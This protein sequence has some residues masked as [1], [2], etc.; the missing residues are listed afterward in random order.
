MKMEK[1]KYYELD[2]I[3]GIIR[4]LSYRGRQGSIYNF[5]YS[6]L[7]QAKKSLNLSNGVYFVSAD[8]QSMEIYIGQTTNGAFR[9]NEHKMKEYQDTAEIYFYAFD[10]QVPNKNLL[11]HIEKEMIKKAQD[12][13]Y[14]LL[15]KTSGNSI[16]LRGIDEQYAEEITPTIINLLK[17]FGI[18]FSSKHK[19]NEQSVSS[20]K[21]IYNMYDELFY[22]KA[23][24][25]ER[26]FTIAREGDVWI[27]KKG[28]KVKGRNRWENNHDEALKNN[29]GYPIYKSSHNLV[30]EDDI[31]QKDLVW[32]SISPLV[33]FAKGHSAGTGW[34]SIKNKDGKTP[35]QVYREDN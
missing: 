12:S 34:T 32:K 3:D 28:S 31:L 8:Y 11:D 26:D 10:G 23:F 7:N 29:A 25:N 22:G 13:M 35:H 2:F 5:K 18:D 14:T 15:N 27:L 17:V 16:E 21:T 19:E 6:N 1:T 33:A 9:F 24:D 30:D 4:K 20:Q